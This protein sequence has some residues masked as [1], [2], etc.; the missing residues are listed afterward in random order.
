M[1]TS[2][3]RIRE[4]LEPC[5]LVSCCEQREKEK[6][7]SLAGLKRAGTEGKHECRSGG[8]KGKKQ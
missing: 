1:Q 4:G 2:L 7:P 6:D 3:E 8:K 5:S